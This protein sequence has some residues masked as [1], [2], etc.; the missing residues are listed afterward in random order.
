MLLMSLGVHREVLRDLNEKQLLSSFQTQPILGL[1][2]I[3][4]LTS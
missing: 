4:N 2:I 1:Y 3:S